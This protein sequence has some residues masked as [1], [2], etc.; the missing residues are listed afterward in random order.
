MHDL[1]AVLLVGHHKAWNCIEASDSYN[2]EQKI[3]S[4]Q[5]ANFEAVWLAEW[6]IKKL[7]HYGEEALGISEL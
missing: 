3:G 6:Q 1:E 2:H 4:I 7:Q 5:V